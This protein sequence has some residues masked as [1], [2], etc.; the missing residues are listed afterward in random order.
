MK[1]ITQQELIRF[2]REIA[3]LFDQGHIPYLIHLSG[4]N[5]DELLKIFEEVNEG[6][7]VF[8]THRNHYHFLLCG[9]SPDKLKKFILE[10]K[11]MF[12]FDRKLNFYSSSIVAG[13]PAIAAGVAWA[14]K[15][16]KSKNKVWCFVGDGAE[17]EGNF[18]EAVA[19]VQGWDLPC[20]FIIEDNDRSVSS[21]KKD[22][23]GIFTPKW[24]D[25]VIKYSYE[26]TYPH[27]GSG[28]G[29]W[30]NFE[31][32][33]RIAKLPQR[34]QVPQK[35][36]EIHNS[37][38]YK[39]AV[40]KSMEILSKDSNT[41][42]VGYNVRYGSAY[43]TLVN[44]PEEQRI[45]TPLAENLMSGLAMGM[46][47][48][49][50]KPVL[51]FERHDFVLTAID[52]LVHQLSKV[53]IISEGEFKMP[54]IIRAVVGGIKPFYAGLTHTQDYSDI[55]KRFFSFPVYTPNTPE[56]VLSAYKTAA[57]I[58]GPVL[59]SEKKSLY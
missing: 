2:E 28:S 31:R 55:F 56:E 18:Y 54:V 24:P 9:G 11:S 52:I 53:H 58:E 17:D 30:I 42:F 16:K 49:G 13:T 21:T 37:L 34:K 4:G 40:K 50:F 36:E 7:Y 46:S 45:E 6:D 44:I 59:I 15:K 48:E 38:N 20:T 3:E 8:S 32:E 19:Y 51:F 47:L 1:K 14:L 26:P 25:C 43:G 22:R 41:Y 12:V 27:G 23:R 39:D 35:I 29:K 57:E 5:E 10:G 33:P